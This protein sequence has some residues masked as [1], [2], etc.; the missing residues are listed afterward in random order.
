MEE[1]LIQYGGKC[2]ETGL[3]IL[4]IALMVQLC[5]EIN[6]TRGDLRLQNG[7][8]GYRWSDKFKRKM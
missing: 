6:L 3:G 1:I 7:R 4:E 5:K 2:A 8:T